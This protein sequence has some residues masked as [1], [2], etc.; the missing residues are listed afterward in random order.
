VSVA[1]PPMS[2]D[3]P[4]SRDDMPHDRDHGNHEKD[5]NQA[6]AILTGRANG[7]ASGTRERLAHQL[8]GQQCRGD[9][10]HKGCLRQYGVPFRTSVPG[11]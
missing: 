2:L 1:V 4:P 7:S 11:K 8:G 3:R 9:R 5:V 6:A 10:R